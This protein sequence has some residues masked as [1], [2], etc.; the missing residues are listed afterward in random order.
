M[1]PTADQCPGGSPA[2]CVRA[3]IQPTISAGSSVG[4]STDL[5]QKRFDLDP[6]YRLCSR[7]R[8]RN[9][10]SPPFI[11]EYRRYFLQDLKQPAGRNGNKENPNIAFETADY[12]PWSK[13]YTCLHCDSKIWPYPNYVDAEGRCL[14]CVNHGISCEAC[15]TTLSIFLR[16]F[17]MEPE[18]RNQSIEGQS[19]CEWSGQPVFG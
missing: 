9:W 17:E 2:V 16:A 7:Y 1:C 19:H 6:I 18:R 10:R 4:T 13:A 14:E 15:D 8:A 5:R 11:L 12:F 3:R